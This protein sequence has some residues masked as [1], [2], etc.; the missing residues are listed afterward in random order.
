MKDE[1]PEKAALPEEV[2]LQ[3]QQNKTPPALR[4]SRSGGDTLPARQ[5]SAL[6]PFRL[7]K[8]SATLETPASVHLQQ[9]APCPRNRRRFSCRSRTM[10]H[11]SQEC[12]SGVI[13]VSERIFSHLSN[14]SA[15]PSLFAPSSSLGPRRFHCP[16]QPHVC[17]SV[18][19]QTLPLQPGK[20]SASSVILQVF[21]RVGR[22]Q[23]FFHWP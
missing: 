13:F 17:P 5:A 22:A 9:R 8:G 21:K 2:W 12:P 7:R 19:S 1:T 20:S 23:I 11:S 4:S 10:L 14:P 16:L 6:L 18:R 15:S 3:G